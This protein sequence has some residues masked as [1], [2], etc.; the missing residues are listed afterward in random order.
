MCCW[1][2]LS[3][4]WFSRRSSFR[5]CQV[6]PAGPSRSP[7]IDVCS[8][9]HCD[10]WVFGSFGVSDRARLRLIVLRVLVLSLLLTLVGRLW[11][12][13]VLAGPQ[14]QQAAADNQVRDIVAAAPRGLIVDDF[15]KPWATNRTALVI[16]VDRVALLRQKGCG[17]SKH[18]CPVLDRLAGLL[19][20]PYQTLVDKTT[21]CGPSAPVGCWN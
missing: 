10:C 7:P 4:M 21:L 19:H 18:V 9:E 17:S 15:G 16:A 3:T 6:R 2:Q 20:T 8:S 12:L 5:W 1:P 13:Q 14:Y 11:Y